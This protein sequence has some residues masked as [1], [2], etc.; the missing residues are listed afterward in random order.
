MR[1]CLH[2]WK[3]IEEPKHKGWSYDGLEKLTAMC[4]CKKC[5]KKAERQFAGKYVG[6]LFG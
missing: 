6:Q 4:V 1:F 2:D 3:R 5:E